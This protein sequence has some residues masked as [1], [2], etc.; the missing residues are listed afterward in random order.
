MN[1]GLTIATWLTGPP[2][3]QLNTAKGWSSTQCVLLP[4]Q[5]PA[6]LCLAQGLTFQRRLSDSCVPVGKM[7]KVAKSRRVPSPKQPGTKQTTPALTPLHRQGNGG[8]KELNTCPSQTFRLGGSFPPQ[9]VLPTV[10]PRCPTQSSAGSG[11]IPDGE[12]NLE[13]TEK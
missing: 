3:S 11:M 1:F 7:T 5:L 6:D 8:S 10:N 9:G 4:W 13:S 2:A 12:G